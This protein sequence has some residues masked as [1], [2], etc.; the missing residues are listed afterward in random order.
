MN[1]VT[2]EAI[3]NLA[4]TPPNLNGQSSSSIQ[5]TAPISTEKGYAPGNGREAYGKAALE[6]EV[7]KLRAAS[8]G[9]RNNTLNEAAFA[10]GQLVGGGVLTESDVTDELERVALQIG[11]EPTEM[12]STIHSGL[13]AGMR[14]PRKAPEPSLMRNGR[15]ENIVPNS[16]SL[17]SWELGKPQRRREQ[18]RGA[19]GELDAQARKPRATPKAIQVWE[20]HEPGP[21]PFAI[22][23]LVPDGVVTTLYGDGGQGKSYLALYLA[24]LS[25]LGL[26]FAGRMVEKR[27]A[28]YIDGELDDTEFVRRAYSVARGLGLECPPTGLYYYQLE[29]PLSSSEE[30]QRVKFE[31]ENCGATFLILD[32]LTMST[33][34]ADPKDAQDMV[35]IIK[36]LETLGTVVAIDHIPGATPGANLSQYREFGSVFKGNGARSRIQV[37][38]AE[39]GGQTLIHKKTNFGPL[40]KPINL[41]MTFTTSDTNMPVVRFE[42]I[43]ANDP[44]MAG[45]ENHLPARDRVYRELCNWSLGESGGAKAE[46][47]AGP[48][49]MGVHN[50]Q[51]YL[52]TL[53]KEQRA[54]SKNGVWWAILEKRQSP[55]S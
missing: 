13:T 55:S 53:K 23:G 4:T 31:V 30:Q 8:V 44:R 46:D 47:L 1:T 28:L 15:S 17:K 36:Y 24:T 45:I 26:S 11:L 9:E 40:S 38:K 50:V 37:I 54:D 2:L 20:A 10:L 51:N 41:A 48:L 42:N 25:C 7:A 33:Y 22:E 14:Q 39:G 49:G 18:D 35:G 12:R 43:E 16:Q 3:Q 29:G 21:R 32:S 6:G 34:G 52:T 19:G 5:V 27:D